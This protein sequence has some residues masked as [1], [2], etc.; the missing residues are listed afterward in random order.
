MMKKRIFVL[1]ICIALL[2][3]G[4]S[5]RLVGE[6]KAKEA[7]LAMIQQAFE[8][9]L[10]DAVVT[11]DYRER[12]GVTYQKGESIQYGTEE[13]IRFYEIK[14]NP[15]EI[16]NSDYYAEVNAKT[17]VAYRANKSIALIPRTEEQLA[18]AAALKPGD[19]LPVENYV[20]DEIGSLQQAE[21]WVRAHFEPDTPLLRTVP[22]SSMT[23]GVNFPLFIVSCF[24]VFVD[25]TIYSVD[26][27]WP[28]MD[29]TDVYLCNQ[30]Y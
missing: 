14:V 28:T 3:S 30:E 8:V 27:C 13:P 24:V 29:V 11:V 19:D 22:N 10:T 18:Q 16:G 25:G 17:G 2:L 12:P 26:V 23:D 5:P 20:V 21:D 15:D 7:G 1:F 6:A 9:D 4:C